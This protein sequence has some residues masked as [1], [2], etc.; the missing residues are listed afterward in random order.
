MTVRSGSG[1][2]RP[3][4]ESTEERC[5]PTPSYRFQPCSRELQLTAAG[6]GDGL[7]TIYCPQT[8]MSMWMALEKWVRLKFLDGGTR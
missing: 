7:Y 6:S 1:L 4:L 5:P 3:S 2:E 8:V